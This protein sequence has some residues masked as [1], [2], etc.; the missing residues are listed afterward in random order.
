VQAVPL[1]PWQLCQIALKAAC[2]MAHLHKRDVVHMDL[3]SLNVF[4][5][6]SLPSKPRVVVGDLGLSRLRRGAILSGNGTWPW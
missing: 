6:L 3:K 2:G 4:V 1:E 5:D